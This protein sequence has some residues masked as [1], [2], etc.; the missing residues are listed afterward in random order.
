MAVL[1]FL[2]FTFSFH[3][4]LAA[5]SRVRGFRSLARIAANQR[6]NGVQELGA[7]ESFFISVFRSLRDGGATPMKNRF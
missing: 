3:P 1:S 2:A 5:Q 6:S 7:S 4:Y